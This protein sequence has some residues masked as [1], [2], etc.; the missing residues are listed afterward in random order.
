MACECNIK[1]EE[2]M[3]YGYLKGM[4]WTQRTIFLSSTGHRIADTLI[5]KIKK[6]Y[7]PEQQLYLTA[8]KLIPGYR[9]KATNT[10]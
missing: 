10:R 7:F 5:P 4:G 9:K 6:K 3:A 8:R 1:N 2:R